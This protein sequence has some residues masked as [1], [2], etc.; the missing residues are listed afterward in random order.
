MDINNPEH[1]FNPSKKDTCEYK[2]GMLQ[3]DKAILKSDYEKAVKEIER[4]QE[5]LSKYEWTNP[6][7]LPSTDTE[8]AIKLLTDA[9]REDTT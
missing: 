2:L 5:K 3:M 4:L 7:G 1:P 9:L 6:D 8:L